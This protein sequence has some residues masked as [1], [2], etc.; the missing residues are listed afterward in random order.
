MNVNLTESREQLGE[1]LGLEKP[2]SEDVF[3]CALN[4]E[5]YAHNLIVCRNQ[6]EFLRHLL[7]NPPIKNYTEDE[8]GEMSSS[9]LMVKAAKAL[10]GW[11]KTGFSTVDEEM[12]E[13]RENACLSC[14]YRTTSY[15]GLH[16]LVTG[17]VSEKIGSRAADSVCKLCGCGISK[18]IRLTS[19]SCPAKDSANSALS[20]WGEPYRQPE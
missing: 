11:A 20:R 7:S 19:E 14:E 15:N 17:K 4:D 3:L 12:I 2:V 9:V 5:T 10:V 13:R 6:P 8:P 18:K 16:K 1:L